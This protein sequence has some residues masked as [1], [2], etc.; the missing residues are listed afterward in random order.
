M[1]T[2]FQNMLQNF[3]EALERRNMQDQT[4]SKLYIDDKRHS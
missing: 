3:Y 1:G 4:I 2:G